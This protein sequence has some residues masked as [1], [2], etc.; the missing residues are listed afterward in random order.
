MFLSSSRGQCRPSVTA[1]SYWY[2]S[3]LIQVKSFSFLCVCVSVCMC[4]CVCEALGVSSV[5][6][7]KT[8]RL[9]KHQG[10]LPPT[11]TPTSPKGGIFEFLNTVSVA[12]GL[13]KWGGDARVGLWYKCQSNSCSFFVVTIYENIMRQANVNIMFRSQQLF[14]TIFWYIAFD[15]WCCCPP[16][17]MLSHQCCFNY[18]LLCRLFCSVFTKIMILST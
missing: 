8:P 6:F 11:F 18:G 13:W 5:W 16:Q 4:V 10:W 1:P 12:D 9:Q 7:T 2:L 14:K 17:L 3:H 15:D